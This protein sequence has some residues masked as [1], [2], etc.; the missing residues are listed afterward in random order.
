MNVKK[1]GT[2]D[3]TPFFKDIHTAVHIIWLN[4]K[5][6]YCYF[7]GHKWGSWGLTNSQNN[8]IRQCTRCTAYDHGSQ[9]D[10]NTYID[11]IREE[12]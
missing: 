6:M 10:Y 1:G 2:N 4:L 7:I 12:N 5:D 3:M 11:M 9:A 8:L